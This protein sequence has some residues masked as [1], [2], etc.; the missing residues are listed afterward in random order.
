MLNIKQQTIQKSVTISGVGLHTGVQTKPFYL[1]SDDTFKT[2]LPLANFAF[3]VS[4]G[5]PQEVRVLAQRSL[6]DVTVKY[7]INGGDAQSAPTEE[8]SGG[9]RYGGG[10]DV[11][12]RVMSGVVTGTDPGDTVEVWF[13]GGGE[14]SDSFTYTAAVMCIGLTRQSP[15]R[16]PEPRTNASTCGVML[17]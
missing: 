16:M 7:S 2:G 10:T 5:D 8:W 13:E 4:Y 6:G 14:T 3:P 1:K 12:Y 11:H 9:D 15:W 17:R